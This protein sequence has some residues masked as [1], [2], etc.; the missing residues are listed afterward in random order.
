M[1]NS[2]STICFLIAG[3]HLAGYILRVTFNAEAIATDAGLY[4]LGPQVENLVPSHRGYIQLP[5]ISW[6][7]WALLCAAHCHLPP[8]KNGNRILRRLLD[9]CL[10]LFHIRQYLCNLAIYFG[11]PGDTRAR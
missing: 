1:G 8:P 3:Y 2:V 11:G 10:C 6:G 9:S 7:I 5:H 4:S